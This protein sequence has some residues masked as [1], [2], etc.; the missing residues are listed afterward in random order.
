LRLNVLPEGAGRKKSA[1]HAPRLPGRIEAKTLINLDERGKKKKIIEGICKFFWGA[2]AKAFEWCRNFL[3]SKERK[4]GAAG[5]ARQAG[6]ADLTTLPHGDSQIAARS[7]GL[8][9]GRAFPQLGRSGVRVGI[10]VSVED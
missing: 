3:K 7:F 4:E 2:L 8:A 1:L 9:N 5:S 6:S 10:E